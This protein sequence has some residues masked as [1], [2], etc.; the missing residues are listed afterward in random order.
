[1]YLGIHLG[2]DL[3]SEESKEPQNIYKIYKY[4]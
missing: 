4:L 2:E 1:M 3:F